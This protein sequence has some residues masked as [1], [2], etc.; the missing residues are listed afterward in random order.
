[1]STNRSTHTRK[2]NTNERLPKMLSLA[3][4][5]AYTGFKPKMLRSFIRNGYLPRFVSPDD[6]KKIF[7]SRHELDKFI[8]TYSSYED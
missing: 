6:G 3:Q 7:L 5:S 4:A 1:M 2:E 8:A